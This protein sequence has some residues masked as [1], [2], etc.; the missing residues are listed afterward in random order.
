[1]YTHFM[2]ISLFSGWC[3]I[4]QVHHG[5]SKMVSTARLPPLSACPASSYPASDDDND[6]DDDD[7]DVAP[8]F[9]ASLSSFGQASREG[10]PFVWLLFFIWPPKE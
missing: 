4:S 10:H 6:V 3:Q 1:M 5:V 7:D 2:I 9:V 8:T